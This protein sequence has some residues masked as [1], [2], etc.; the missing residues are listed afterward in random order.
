MLYQ[1]TDVGDSEAGTPDAQPSD[2]KRVLYY[3]RKR[4][5]ETASKDMITAIVFDGDDER[6][7]AAISRCV[8]L[9][10]VRILG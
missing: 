6:A 5:N 2:A 8:N 10:A 1:L 4:A 7:R 3:L 9:K